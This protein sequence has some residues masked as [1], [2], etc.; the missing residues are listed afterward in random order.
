[1]EVARELATRGAQVILLTRQPPSDLF[2]SEYIDDL[3]AR[4]MQSSRRG[5]M[6]SIHFVAKVRIEC[7][8]ERSTCSR[9]LPPPQHPQPSPTRAARTPRRACDLRNL[10]ELHRNECA[11]IVSA[12]LLSAYTPLGCAYS[13]G[14]L[15]VRF[16]T[17]PPCTRVIVVDP[18]LTRTPGMRR[19]LT[20][21]SLWGLALSI[22]RHS[23]INHPP[24]PRPYCCSIAAYRILCAPCT[25]G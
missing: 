12:S 18:G 23:L 2:L 17:L 24:S 11:K 20:G 9:Q 10:L 14:E 25:G 8:E 16:D 13:G 22:S 4:I 21:G 19:W 3:R 5:G 6:L 15:F 1:V 7:R